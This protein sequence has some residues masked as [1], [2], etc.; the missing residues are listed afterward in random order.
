MPE[1][2]EVETLKRQLEQEVLGEPILGV[3][4]FDPNLQGA[5][6]LLCGELKGVHRHG[7]SLVFALDGHRVVLR[8]GMSGRLKLGKPDRTPRLT[9]LLPNKEIHLIDPRRFARIEAMRNLPRG[10]DPFSPSASR[11]ISVRAKRARKPLKAFLMDQEMVLGIGN[12]YACEILYRAGLDPFMPA[13]DLR[14][15]HWDA[16]FSEARGVLG[17]AIALRGTTIADWR[18]LYGRPGGYQERLF[19]YGR[20]GKPCPRCRTPI[21]RRVLQGRGTWFCPLCQRQ[22]GGKG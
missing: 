17:E 2:P 15:V 5:A 10:V 19:V 14:E 13:G 9:F 8:L 4:V 1:L 12:I 16:V 3:R 7:K 22:K 21:L 20:E 6:C 18:D 11:E